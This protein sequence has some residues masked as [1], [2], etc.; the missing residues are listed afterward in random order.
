MNSIDQQKAQ[1]LAFIYGGANLDGVRNLYETS[2]KR[3]VFDTAVRQ[4][5]AEG[6]I[7]ADGN[8]IELTK[9]GMD[10]FKKHDNYL[11]YVE[12]LRLEEK[13]KQKN[14]R[15]DERMKMSVILLNYLSATKL[16]FAIAG[17]ILGVA[18]AGQARRILSQL[19]LFFGVEV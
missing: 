4:L 14:W 1:I 10:V 6:L 3:H 8:D 2:D 9:E 12:A 7:N 17:Y 18:T 11:N 19:M 15:T 5:K 13:V 16:L